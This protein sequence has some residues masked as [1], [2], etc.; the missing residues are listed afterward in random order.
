MFEVYKLD[1]GYGVV[2]IGHSIPTA[3]GDVHVVIDNLHFFRLVSDDAT[4][5]DFEAGGVHLVDRTF[6]RIGID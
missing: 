1:Y 2:V 4:P 5:G 3:I 6:G